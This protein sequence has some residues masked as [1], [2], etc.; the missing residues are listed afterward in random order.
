MTDHYSPSEISATSARKNEQVVSEREKAIDILIRRCQS[1]NIPIPPILQS[2]KKKVVTVADDDVSP[3]FDSGKVVRM[4]PSTDVDVD[5]GSSSATDDAAAKTKVRLSSSPNQQ[6]QQEPEQTDIL[7]R[8]WSMPAESSS[9][10]FYRNRE[11]SKSSRSI[12]LD[13]L[14]GRKDAD[15]DED[16]DFDNT[17]GNGLTTA[18]GEVAGTGTASDGIIREEKSMV[19]EKQPLLSAPKHNE[20]PLASSQNTTKHDYGRFAAAQDEERRLARIAAAFL[21]DFE[22][23]QAPTLPPDIRNV[24][25]MRLHLRTVRFSI[26]WKIIMT[27]ATAC[28]FVGSC[29]EGSDGDQNWESYKETNLMERIRRKERIIAFCTVVPVTAFALDICFM[30][31]LFSRRQ[32]SVE[33]MLGVASH[34]FTTTSAR[35]GNITE[36][37][38]FVPPLPQGRTVGGEAE[39]M[40]AR[41]SRSWWWAIPVSFFLISLS[42]ETWFVVRSHTIM[43]RRIWSSAFKP[44]VFFYV[45]SKARN[46]LDALLRVIRIVVRVILIELFLI[47][48]FGAVAVQLFGD[49]ESFRGLPISFLSMFQLSTTV[50][51]PSLWMPVY[52]RVGRKASIFFV[53]FLITSVFYLHS[54]VLS[55]VFQS[56]MDGMSAIRE[57]AALDREKSLQLSYEALCERNED[58]EDAV[59]TAAPTRR[60]RDVLAKMRPHYNVVKLNALVQA[61][62]PIHSGSVDYNTFRLK[63]PKALNMSVRSRRP[64]NNLSRLLELFGA[65]VALINL[66]Y[67]VLASSIFHTWW[68]KASVI[69]IGFVITLLGMIELIVRLVVVKILRAAAVSSGKPNITFDGLATV[70]A[71]TSMAGLALYGTEYKRALDCIFSGRAIDM[72]RCLRLNNEARDIVKRSS[73]VIP[74]LLGPVLLIISAMHFFVYAGIAIWGNKVECGVRPDLTPFYDLNN[75]NSY[76]SGVITIFQV[77]VINDWHAI[78]LVFILPGSAT[79]VLVYPYFVL[80][81]LVLTSVLLN[82]MIA[83]FVNAF[84]TKATETSMVIGKEHS[85]RTKKSIRHSGSF[86]SRSSYSTLDEHEQLVTISERQGFDSILRTIAG[87]GDDDDSARLCS[88]VLERFEQIS[89][90]SEKVGYLVACQK[91]NTRY[92]NQRMMNI[93]G[94]FMDP[95][96]MHQIV[97]EMALEV[98]NL[99]ED[100]ST[101]SLKRTFHAPNM[102][103]GLEMRASILEE[104]S[105]ICVFVGKLV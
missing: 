22:S 45:S 58:E 16:E 76:L 17:G 79:N 29:F 18:F 8:T 48:T 31:I 62:D 92:G 66:V 50:V 64:E 3:L 85:E 97:G 103:Q 34:Y 20:D 21:E 93:V 78:A 11:L 39:P 10:I 72:V 15:E 80:A 94:Q 86:L 38:S 65:F 87:D 83:F 89:L 26:F 101:A 63:I 104:G 32:Q 5:K 4:H 46:A 57:H 40:S 24:T 28:L 9:S 67:V 2:K 42:I 35:D 59:T 100:R 69:P 56:Y 7:H 27:F 51:N 95:R 33:S 84:V 41:K 53:I 25:D 54:L 52:A 73:E 6:Q 98:A 61:V 82:V 12:K 74:A 81:N 44:V 60:I 1:E 19:G 30:A 49:F 77:L 88:H 71:V 55:V 23:G 47:F 91:S 99:P 70:A 43:Q 96:A 75:F 14:R 102:S 36:S 90:P 68:W 13:L 37:K 105:S